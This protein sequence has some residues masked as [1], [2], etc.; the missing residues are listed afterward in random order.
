[1]SASDIARCSEQIL[2]AKTVR[3]K[4]VVQLKLDDQTKLLPWIDERS[5]EP[6]AT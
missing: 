5:D 2:K 6:T 1:M 3:N 4:A